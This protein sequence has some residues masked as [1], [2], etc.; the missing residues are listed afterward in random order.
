MTEPPRV[1]VHEFKTSVDLDD[2]AP[3]RIALGLHHYHFK[4]SERGWL[5]CDPEADLELV[6]MRYW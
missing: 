5:L 6:E 4:P 3:C 1:H 2:G